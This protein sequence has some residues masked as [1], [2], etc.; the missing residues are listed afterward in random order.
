M[1]AVSWL[2]ESKTVIF[3]NLRDVR[4]WEDYAQAYDKATTMLLRHRH[5]VHCIVDIGSL[6][7]LPHGNPWILLRRMTCI[8]PQNSGLIIHVGGKLA[9]DSLRAATRHH[10]PDHIRF[11]DTLEDAYALCGLAVAQA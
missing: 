9:T 7:A 2:D 11:V 10:L 5:T 8:S 4:T 1:C 3:L 6:D